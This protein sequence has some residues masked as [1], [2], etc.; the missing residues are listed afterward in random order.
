MALRDPPGRIAASAGA[1]CVP[2]CHPLNVCGIH[3]ISEGTGAVVAER[4]NEPCKV[5]SESRTGMAELPTV[6]KDFFATAPIQLRP[7]NGSASA[8]MDEPVAPRRRAGAAAAAYAAGAGLDIEHGRMRR[9]LG[10]RNGPADRIVQGSRSAPLAEGQP[11]E[12]LGQRSDCG[13]HRQPWR[14]GRLGGGG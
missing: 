7:A 12:A 4:P 3:A 13:E 5:Y 11:R 2:P 1:I 10:E 14:G 8:G 6:L 9:V